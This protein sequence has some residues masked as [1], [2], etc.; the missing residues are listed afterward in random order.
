[1]IE[2]Y[3]YVDSVNRSSDASGNSYSLT[4]TSPLKNVVRVDLVS[5]KVPNTM[6]NITNGVAAIS[7]NS[8]PFTI[9]NGFYSAI[10]L[11][12]T[13][14]GISSINVDYSPDDGKMI[15]WSSTSFTVTPNTLEMARAT[16]L[17]NG[18]TYTGV[19][20]SSTPFASYTKYTGKYIVH[21]D[22]VVDLSIT[23][24]V[25]LD[26][27]ELRSQ[28]MIDSKSFKGSTYPGSTIARSFGAIPLDVPSSAI[29][30]FKETSDYS[31]H[32]AFTSPIPQ[33]SRFTIQWLDVNGLPLI[34]NG[35][36]HNSFLLR[37]HQLPLFEPDPLPKDTDEDVLMRKVQRAI[38][39][40]LPPPT[41]P[42]K[43][44]WGFMFLVAVLVLAAVY[45]KTR[46]TRVAPQPSHF[47]PTQ[48]HPASVRR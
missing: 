30:I 41:P 44:P 19:L 28:M 2:S 36:E 35:F 32:V 25:F 16:G 5:A 3:V 45:F 6:Y 40:A 11:A 22:N 39:D 4:L 23:D 18:V 31:M 8:T 46:T 7:F 12:A 29:K 42:H 33:I 9:V 20:Y 15:F 10:G 38:Q 13:L 24:F 27:L 48:P 37:V 26:I 14:Y 21:S 17:T 47:V 43:R 34:F 1:M